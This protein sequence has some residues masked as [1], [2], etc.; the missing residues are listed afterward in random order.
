MEVVVMGTFSAIGRQ[1]TLERQLSAISYQLSAI[2]YQLS[3]PLMRIVHV[4]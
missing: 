3:A 1:V 2:S 4:Q